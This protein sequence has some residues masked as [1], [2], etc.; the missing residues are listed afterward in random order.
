MN[1]HADDS[2]GNLVPVANPYG[3]STTVYTRIDGQLA[4]F[5]IGTA[6]HREAI[7][8]VRQEM[9]MHGRKAVLAVINGDVA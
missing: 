1:T 7:S 9:R 5:H 4:A 3:F 8:E 6:D 2:F